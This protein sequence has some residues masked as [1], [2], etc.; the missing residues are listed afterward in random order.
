[1]FREFRIPKKKK[2]HL[3][4]RFFR[5]KQEEKGLYPRKK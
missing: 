4:I 3:A 5:K 1:M 2:M